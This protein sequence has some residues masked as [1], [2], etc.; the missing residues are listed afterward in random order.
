VLRPSELTTREIEGI[1]W[2]C[3]VVER[4]ALRVEG[5]VASGETE[6]AALA[7]A[8]KKDWR[9]GCKITWTEPA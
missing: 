1:W 6:E 4:G 7:A 3:A 9:N 8:G 2:A 5:L